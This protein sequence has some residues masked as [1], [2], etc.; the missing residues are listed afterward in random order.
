MLRE[1]TQDPDAVEPREESPAGSAAARR[2][3]GTSTPRT[4]EADVRQLEAG[5]DALQAGDL[6]R[7]SR[8]GSVV[9]ALLPVAAL[10]A[11]IY[12]WQMYVWIAGPRPDILPGP[13]D[14]LGTLGQL[15]Q[16]GEAQETIVT[17]LQRG[18]FGFLI[19]AAVST[20]LGLL[21]AQNKNL[22]AAFRPL[23]SGLQVLPS[24][25]WVPAAI[26][27]FGLTD[28]TVYFVVLMGAVPSII[29][30][31]ISG[32][33]QV[34]PQF[35]RVGHVLGASR[36]Q[37]AVKIILPA[38]L[39]GYLAGLKQGWAFSWR[40][41]MAAEIIAV[42]GS[43]GFGLGSLLQQGR[44]LSAMGIVVSAIV[45]ILFIGIVVELL[46]FAPLERRLLRGRGLLQGRAS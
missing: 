21:L 17:S 26:I 25:A 10:A 28:A 40:S 22:R 42:G 7:G 39:P 45:L 38:A 23:V 20:P 12:V 6:R 43:M 9:K 19:A 35:H 32:V 16:N 46:V 13:L 3:P 41:L 5:L 24:V 15:W 33:D 34:P 31:L 2:N 44:D 8:R 29:N 30:G 18:V 14:V 27:W 11:V 4:T 1:T 36:W 37:L